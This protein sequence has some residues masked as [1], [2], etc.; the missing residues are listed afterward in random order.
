M[1]RFIDSLGALALAGLLAAPG[2]A[3]AQQEDVDI[4][5]E[6]E[7]ELQPDED[8]DVDVDVDIDEPALDPPIVEMA[9]TP[10]RPY[11]SQGVLELGGWG[12]ISSTTDFT[13]INFN[14]Q[15]GWFILDNVQLSAI[16]GLYAA[17]IEGE[18]STF[19][20]ALLEPSYHMNFTEN[21]LGFV[22]L[23][24]GLAWSRVGGPGFALQPRVGANLLIGRSGIFTPA[25]FAS[26]STTDIVRTPEGSLLG[27]D[28]LWGLAAGYTVMW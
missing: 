25:L 27:V 2:A 11:G 13:L 17:N 18:R 21:V 20:S 14:P 8:I 15:V 6:E 28:L 26:W 9:G 19:F 7:R 3:F 4:D 22:G 10:E 24:G 1:K 23:G 12:A 16:V 5:I